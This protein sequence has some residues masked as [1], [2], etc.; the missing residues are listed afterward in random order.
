MAWQYSPSGHDCRSCDKE[1]V[2]VRMD[3][4]YHPVD[5]RCEDCM[6]G[7]QPVQTITALGVPVGP[8]KASMVQVQPYRPS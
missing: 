5:F 8:R 4:D 3:K 1:A 6:D 7:N 2:Y